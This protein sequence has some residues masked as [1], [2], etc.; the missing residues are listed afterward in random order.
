[1]KN[2]IHTSNTTPPK[3]RSIEIEVDP[4]PPHPLRDYDSPVEIFHWHPRYEFGTQIHRHTLTEFRETMAERGSEILAL[5]PLYLMDHSGLSVSVDPFSCRWDSG[6][7]GWV[8]I[9]RARAEELGFTADSE[10]TSILK[11]EVEQYNRYLRGEVYGFVV[12]GL[13][14]DVLDS[15]GGFFDLEDC[16]ASAK[17]AAEHTEDPAIQRQAEELESRATLAGGTIHN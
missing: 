5:S 16:E 7:V 14:G 9:T 10:W 17:A 6:Q 12:L 2:F 3:V 13:D 15:C 1:M 11:A 4:D 8:V